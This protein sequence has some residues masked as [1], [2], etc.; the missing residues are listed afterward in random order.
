MGFV[1]TF[2]FGIAASY[3]ADGVTIS[4][5]GLV[6]RR[7]LFCLFLIMSCLLRSEDRYVMGVNEQYSKIFKH[8]IAFHL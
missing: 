5:D 3:G 1:A 8:G 7:F 6:V 2:Y 4:R